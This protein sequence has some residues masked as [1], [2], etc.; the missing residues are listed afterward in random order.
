VASSAGLVAGSKV[1]LAA[2]QTAL[3]ATWSVYDIP[4]TTSFRIAM[5]DPTLTDGIGTAADVTLS[6]LVDSIEEGATS[7]E[8]ADLDVPIG[9]ITTLYLARYTTTGELLT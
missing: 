2:M 6:S 7:R 1:K 5:A 3:N 8:R 4:G 9:S